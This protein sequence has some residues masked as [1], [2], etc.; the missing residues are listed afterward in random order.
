MPELPEVEAVC[1]KLNEAGILGKRILR[2]RLVR[3]AIARPQKAADLESTVEGRTVERIE[4]RAKNLLL[5]LSG[6]IVLRVHLRM[7]GNLFVIPDVRFL[8][9]NAR[10]YFEFSKHRALVFH[11]PRALGRI[12]VHTEAELAQLLARLGPE[13]LSPEF[14]PAWL[15]DTA[16]ASRKPAKLFLMDQNALAGLGNIYA[17]EALFHARIH[18]AKPMNRLRHPKLDALHRSIVGVLTD[19]VQSA[20]KAYSGPAQFGEAESFSCFVYDREGDSCLKCR[21]KVRR[22]RQGGRSTYYCPGC[23]T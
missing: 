9:A 17:A 19:A 23:Q 21:R 22:I 11:D 7:T 1:R 16:A 3:P 2:A 8:P 10:A 18:P 14:T 4:R 15:R 6:G 12:H 5:H 20:C 13:P